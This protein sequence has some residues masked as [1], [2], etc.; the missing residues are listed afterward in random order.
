MRKLCFCKCTHFLL[1]L[2]LSTVII[3][4]F[5]SYTNILPLIPLIP[6]LIPRIPTLIPRIPTLIPRIPHILIIPPLIPH[7]PIIP[8]IPFPDS[9]F[10]LLQIAILYYTFF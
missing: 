2:S 8:L 9:P 5:H 4:Q 6:T 1:F 10:R 7:I 3:Q